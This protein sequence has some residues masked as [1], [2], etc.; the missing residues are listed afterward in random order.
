MN[1]SNFFDHCLGA[2]TSSSSTT[3]CDPLFPE[4]RTPRVAPCRSPPPRCCRGE[5][6]YSRLVEIDASP[7]PLLYRPRIVRMVL[8]LTAYLKACGTQLSWRIHFHPGSSR[9]IG[10]F[11]GY[12]WRVC[13]VLGPSLF[14]WMKKLRFHTISF[15]TPKVC[16]ATTGV[17]DVQ[18]VRQA[19]AFSSTLLLQPG[20]LT[21]RQRICF[22]KAGFF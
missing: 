17:P 21:L 18:V 12:R 9:D 15:P 5:R 7:R 11:G 20:G 16:A 22:W 2:R 3:I 4:F 1:L 10:H 8:S 19:P 13:T 6:P 14:P